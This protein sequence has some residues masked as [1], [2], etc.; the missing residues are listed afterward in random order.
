MSLID[1]QDEIKVLA[2]AQDRTYVLLQAPPGFG[3]THLLKEVKRRLR[4]QW[5]IVYVDFSRQ[6]PR[7]S[8]PVGKKE[9]LAAIWRAVDVDGPGPPDEIGKA[10]N[11]LLSKFTAITQPLLLIL[12]SVDIIDD[13]TVTKWLRSEIIHSIVEYREEGQLPTRC[14]ISGFILGENW[15]EESRGYDAKQGFN[16]VTYLPPFE[17]KDINI[18]LGKRIDARRKANEGWE[19]PREEQCKQMARYIRRFSGGHPKLVDSALAEIATKYDFRPDLPTFFNRAWYSQNTLPCC[20]TAFD[21]IAQAVR[22]LPNGVRDTHAIDCFAALSIFRCYNNEIVEAVWTHILDGAPLSPDIGHQ[23][24]TF[25]WDHALI[26]Y[27][28]VKKGFFT[29]NFY[30][31]IL[32]NSLLMSNEPRWMAIH[33]LAL[34]YYRKALR[35]LSEPTRNLSNDMTVIREIFYHGSVIHARLKSSHGLTVLRDELQDNVDLLSAY[36]AQSHETP[37]APS[38]WPENLRKLLEYI[39][40]DGEIQMAFMEW[41]HVGEEGLKAIIDHVFQHI[42]GESVAP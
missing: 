5:R 14:F 42:N 29:G 9:A 21:L 25:F 41:D 13:A 35:Q 40:D 24:L 4:R 3:K 37:W 1:R 23:M 39:R 36:H 18:T 17:F 7:E 2:E 26:R 6:F 19:G 30:H 27:D 10:T 11:R 16:V 33:V 31:S 15:R 34:Q 22:N 12:D 38:S 32:D 8:R 28:Q 20:Q